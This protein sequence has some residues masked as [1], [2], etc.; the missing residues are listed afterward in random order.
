M[1]KTVQT[2]TIKEITERNI[3][4]GIIFTKVLIADETLGVPS[5]ANVILLP[6]DDPAPVEA[7][8][9]A[10]VDAICRGENADLCYVEDA[11]REAYG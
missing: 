11:W 3:E 8:I 6:R 1:A 2:L 4:L 10:G 9:I 7:N 5:G